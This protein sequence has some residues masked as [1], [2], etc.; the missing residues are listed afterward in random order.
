M[1]NIILITGP[2]GVGKS[3]TAK[4]LLSK[5]NKSAYIDADWC[6]AINPFHFTKET[7]IA[8]TQN[9]YSM[10]RNYLMCKDIEWIIFPYSLHGERQSIWENVLEELKRDNLEFNLYPVILKCSKEENV[11]RAK[12]DNRDKERIERGMKNT[13]SCYDT[14]TCPFIDTTNLTPDEVADGIINMVSKIEVEFYN[15]VNDD[16][17]KFAV[18]IAKTNGKWIFCKH[19]ERDT[20]EVPGGHREENESIIETAKRELREET[21]AVDFTITPIC[22]YSVKGKTQVNESA[23]DMSY[24][25]LYYADIFSFEEI[26]SEIESILITEDLVDNWTYPLIQPKLIEEAKRRGYLQ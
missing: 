16:L 15:N 14:Y 23:S 3:T 24:G 10:L 19:K 5:L 12:Q 11:R 1:K 9:I 21:G 13:F 20:Y 26:H 25:M 18:I 6:R 7:K 4:S 8:V 17:L 22:A 2:N